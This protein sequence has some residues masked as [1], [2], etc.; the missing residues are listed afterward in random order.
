MMKKPN[1]SGDNITG[2]MQKLA[3]TEKQR[4]PRQD[5][6]DEPHRAFYTMFGDGSNS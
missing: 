5:E 3:A 4:A 1:G 6:S 2:G